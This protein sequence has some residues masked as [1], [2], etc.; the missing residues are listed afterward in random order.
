MRVNAAYFL[1]LAANP[2]VRMVLF[3]LGVSLAGS[4]LWSVFPGP[5]GT[6]LLIISSLVMLISLVAN[7]FSACFALFN[8]RWQLFGE[9]L[10]VFIVV[11]PIALTSMLLSD[12]IHLAVLYPY[13]RLEIARTSNRPVQFY[14][15]DQALSA[16]DGVQ[17][18]TLMYDDSGKTDITNKMERNDEGLCTKRW[19]L[20][21][22][23][24]IETVSDCRI[25][26]GQS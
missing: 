22:H 7:F 24:L 18:R 2:R 25:F 14:W 10:L 6:L 19:R 17:M 9:R 11:I 8:K 21:G 13:Y 16:I 26:S 15:G 3:L 1:I 20:V 12:Y 5:L 4:A 23:F